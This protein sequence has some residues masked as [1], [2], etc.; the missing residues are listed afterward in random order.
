MKRYVSYEIED[1]VDGEPLVVIQVLDSKPIKVD[2][3]IF[4]KK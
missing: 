2:F 1:D 3:I 4:D